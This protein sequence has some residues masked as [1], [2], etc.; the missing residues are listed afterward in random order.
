MEHQAD[1]RLVRRFDSA[2]EDDE[3]KQIGDLLLEAFGEFFENRIFFKQIPHE[4]II[5]LRRGEVVAQCGIDYR[6]MRADDRIIYTLG[7]VDLCVRQTLRGR[8]LGERLLREVIE[9]AGSRAVDYVLLVAEDGRLYRRVGFAPLSAEMR[10]LAVED[11]H[12]VTVVQETLQNEMYSLPIR[13][14][15]PLEARKIDLLGY[16]Y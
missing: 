15:G 13:A 14:A 5:L 7:V 16:M 10:W 11:L 4:R 3:R 1:L 2:L 6:A 8:G 12:S 9:E